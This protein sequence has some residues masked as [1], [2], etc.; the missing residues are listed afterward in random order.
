MPCS[1]TE[2]PKASGVPLVSSP[3][4][5]SDQPPMVTVTTKTPTL[6]TV[7]ITIAASRP[8]VRQVRT[9]ATAANNASS[10]STQGSG[11][12]CAAAKAAAP[13]TVDT[14]SATMGRA[15]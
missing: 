9:D 1:T 15:R 12:P 5:A 8:P 6:F 2:T 13:I 3:T 11:L 7:C 14:T 10:A 4:K